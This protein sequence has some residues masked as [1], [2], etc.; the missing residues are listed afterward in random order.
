MCN[1]VPSFFACDKHSGLWISSAYIFQ[2]LIVFGLSFSLIYI[3][4]NH[5]CKADSEVLNFHLCYICMYKDSLKWN[6]L[7]TVVR[8][9]STY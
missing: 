3:N 8:L 9:R 5:C 6:V 2:Y 7:V 1:Y 4:S